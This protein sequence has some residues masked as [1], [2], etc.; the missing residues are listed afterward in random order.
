[1]CVYEL[2]TLSEMVESGGGDDLISIYFTPEKTKNT[3]FNS[4]NQSIIQSTL[5]EIFKT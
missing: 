1:V 5:N 3:S 2:F 4:T